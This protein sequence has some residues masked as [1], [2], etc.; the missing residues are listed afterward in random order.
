MSDD[1]FVDAK[2]WAVEVKVLEEKVYTVKKRAQ[3]WEDESFRLRRDW[4]R[5]RREKV[6]LVK[7]KRL[8]E[9]DVE[10][11]RHDVN[12]VTR[13][14]DGLIEK[15]NALEQEVTNLRSEVERGRRAWSMEKEMALWI[16]RN[17][18][19]LEKNNSVVGKEEW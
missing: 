17:V 6:M 10:Q 2:D 11:L 8:L 16:G 5:E 14:R 9:S 12:G 19:K 18:S 15:N 1:E 4:E 3:S 13:V 7:E